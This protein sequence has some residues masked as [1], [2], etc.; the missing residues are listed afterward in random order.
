MLCAL[1]LQVKKVIVAL[2]GNAQTMTLV[3]SNNRISDA[4]CTALAAALS[5]RA[6]CPQLLCL[7]LRGNAR[8]TDAAVATLVRTPTPSPHTHTSQRALWLMRTSLATHMCCC[9]LLAGTQREQACVCTC[10]A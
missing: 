5:D 2:K 6:F 4:G 1:P 8:V 7:D 3:L 9:C 10:C